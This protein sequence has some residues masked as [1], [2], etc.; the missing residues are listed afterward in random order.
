MLIQAI[1]FAWIYEKAFAR[2]SGALIS[3]AVVYVA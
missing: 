2:R 1:L 3:R